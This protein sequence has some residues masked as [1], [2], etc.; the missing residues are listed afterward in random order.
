MPVLRGNRVCYT[1]GFTGAL[2]Q[3]GQCQ[4]CVDSD[5]RIIVNELLCYARHHVDRSSGQAIWDA[6]TNFYTADEIKMAK[7]ILWSVYD[8]VL[9]DT[10]DRRDSIAR[11]A[12]E[13]E[14][15]DIIEAMVK[16]SESDTEE[17]FIFVAINL[18][19][20]PNH[21]PEEINVASILQRLINVERKTATMER[22]IEK[23]TESITTLYDTGVHN[24]SYANVAARPTSPS[25][26]PGATTAASPPPSSSPV[27]Q[28]VAIAPAAVSGPAPEPPTR[29]VVSNAGPPI[30]RANGGAR[31]VADPTQAPQPGQPGQRPR[32]PRRTVYGTREHNTLRSAPSTTKLFVFR[33]NKDVTEDDIKQFLN[34]D[35]IQDSDI[36]CVSHENANAKSFKVTLNS[37]DKDRVMSP[38]FWP[39]GVACRLFYERKSN[40]NRRPSISG[41][42]L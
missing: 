32:R 25:S 3:R 1:C 30:Q 18:N 9:P 35:G 2:G 12:Y 39:D 4:A 33:I 21:A 40:E 37:K 31:V 19:R 38:D 41:N 10:H 20:L 29:I 14:A 28:S 16:L 26:T 7:G 27:A 24:N 6:I 17:H 23:N 22:V 8:D 15:W 5:N 42:A 11:S 36:E 34:D 13:R